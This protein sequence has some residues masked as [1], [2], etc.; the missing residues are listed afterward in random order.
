MKRRDTLKSISLS[1]FGLAVLPTEKTVPEQ[2]PVKK[3][4]ISPGRVLDEAAKDAALHAQKFFETAEIQLLTILADIIIPADGKFP[5]ASKVGVVDFIEFMAKDQTGLQ[6]PLRGGLAWLNSEAIRRFEKSFVALST[7]QKLNIIDD[8]AYPEKAP[9]GMSQGV[10]FFNTI[11]GLVVTGYYTTKTGFEDLGYV[12][13][14]P[15]QWEGVPQDVLD[16]YGLSY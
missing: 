9:K 16:K 10:Q 14:R 15:N 2:T 11:R 7:T 4:P 8:I 6:T 5:A 12:G 1:T 3:G 13:N